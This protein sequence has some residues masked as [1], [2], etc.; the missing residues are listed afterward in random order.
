MT[1][2]RR[3]RDTTQRRRILRVLQTAGCHLTAREIH[4]RV[5]RDGHAVG[6]ATIYRALGAF[7]RAGLVE[8]ASIG[9]A[10]RYGLATEHH[11]H[12]VCLGCGR[13]QP[14]DRCPA[15]RAPRGAAA[16]FRVT[17]HRLEFLGYCARCR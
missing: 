5:G 12:L 7:A 17:G 10:V 11:D 13:W 14:L 2:P 8:T 9:G 6:L 4:R 1:G 16:G 3:T 15:P